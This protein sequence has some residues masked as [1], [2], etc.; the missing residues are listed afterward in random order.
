MAKRNNKS[1]EESLTRLEE[2]SNLLESEE[3]GLEESVKLYE[4]GMKLSKEC[5]K[6]LDKAELKITELKKKLESEL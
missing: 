4:E 3:V 1:F 2:I 6:T 5:Y